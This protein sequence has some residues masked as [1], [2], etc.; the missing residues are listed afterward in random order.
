[1][2]RIGVTGHRSFARTAEVGHAVDRLLQRL[3]DGRDDV[4]LWSSLAE[5]AD[6]MVADLAIARGARLVAVLPVAD[7]DY[8][9]DFTTAGSRADFDRLLAVATSVEVTGPDGTGDRTSAYHRAGAAVV[10][11]VDVLVALWDGGPVRGRGGTAEIV[12]L[13]RRA[14]TRVEVVSVERAGVG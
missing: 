3:M 7:D 11:A 5:G 1:M 12:E 4:E 9:H 2:L 10:G 13:A 6:R 14:G 8:R